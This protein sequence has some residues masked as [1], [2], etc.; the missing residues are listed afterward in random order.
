MAVSGDAWEILSEQTKFLG[1]LQ[2]SGKL[3]I[4]IIFL[5]KAAIPTSVLNAQ[6]LKTRRL[7]KMQVF[8]GGR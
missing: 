3:I 8:I 1:L 2:L 6:T 5:Y 7:N 4:E